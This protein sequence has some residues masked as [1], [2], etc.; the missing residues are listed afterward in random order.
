MPSLIYI[1]THICCTR[2]AVKTVTHHEQAIPQRGKQKTKQE[3]MRQRQQNPSLAEVLQR[4][5]QGTDTGA[6]N[7]SSGKIRGAPT[8]KRERMNSCEM[9]PQ[10]VGKDS[11][12]M[13]IFPKKPWTPPPSSLPSCHP[14]SPWQH[15]SLPAT[16]HQTQSIST[17]TTLQS[18]QSL[19]EQAINP[20]LRLCGEDKEYRDDSLRTFKNSLKCIKSKFSVFS[21]NSK[22]QRVTCKSVPSVNLFNSFI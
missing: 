21:R 3:S 18:R 16:S 19:K 15:S 12:Q 11:R 6:A 20:L 8:C 2:T 4:A 7:E 9:K 1:K 5:T 22:G 14:Y 10:S 17:Y 13:P